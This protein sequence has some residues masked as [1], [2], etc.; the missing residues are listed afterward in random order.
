MLTSTIHGVQLLNPQ[1]FCHPTKRASKCG[2]DI[3]PSASARTPWCPACVASLTKASLDAMQ[4]MLDLRGGPTPNAYERD[5]KWN[6]NRLRR[7]IAMQR[8]ESAKRRDQLRR[9]REQ[10]WEEM[11]QRYDFERVRAVLDQNSAGCFVCETMAASYPDE[12]IRSQAVDVA[13]WE[14]PDRLVASRNPVPKMPRKRS[15][16]TAHASRGSPTMRKIIQD[17]RSALVDMN[18]QIEAWKIRYRIERSVRRKHGLHEGYHFQP[19]FWE[20]PVSGVHVRLH[21][22]V[23]RENQRKAERRARGNMSRPRPPCSPLLY[24]ETVGEIEIDEEMVQTIKEKEYREEMERQ[25]RRAAGEVGYLY[26]NGGIDGLEEWEDDVLRSNRDLVS[27]KPMLEHEP[28][29]VCEEEDTDVDGDDDNGD[30]KESDEMDIG[31]T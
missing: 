2:H 12:T 16:K 3:H 10:A 19:G 7:N 9:E 27:R 13:W 8:L 24:S 14:N 30:E 6:T 26:F 22:Q 28:G 29:N 23:A 5:R 11:H 31:K 1:L 25:A 21:Y 18:I 15:Q 17:H 20:S 4:K